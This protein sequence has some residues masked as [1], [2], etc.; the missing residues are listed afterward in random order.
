VDLGRWLTRALSG[1][2]SSVG[3]IESTGRQIG[4][5]LADGKAHIGDEPLLY[6]RMV[7]MGFMP[8]RH[9]DADRT[10]TYELTN[11]PYRDAVGEG[12]AVVCGLHRGLT[13]GL[14]DVL[15]PETE[16]AAFVPRDPYAAGCLIK[17]RGPLA[18]QAGSTRQP[19]PERQ[20]RQGKRGDRPAQ[21]D[22]SS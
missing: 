16:L 11:C 21:R 18:E 7:A 5:E 12:Q 1:V 2:R 4:R 22:R 14:L 19:T 9:V 6:G 15:S 3:D 17:L 13:Q 10:L 20:Q 8:R